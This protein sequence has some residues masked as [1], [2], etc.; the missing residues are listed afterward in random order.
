M[1]Y[2][3]YIYLD[4]RKPIS[5]TFQ[6]VTVAYQPFYVGKGQNERHMDHL[7]ETTENSGNKFKTRKIQKLHRLGLSPIIEQFH[8]TDDEEEA[9]QF[10]TKLICHWGR[11]GID[12]NGIL[13]NR[14]LENKPPNH[15]GRPKSEEQKQKMRESYWKR[16]SQPGYIHPCKGK[17]SKV[18]EEGRKKISA[19]HKGKPKSE[20]A[21]RKNSEAKKLLLKDPTKHPMFGKHQSEA[22]KQAISESKIG[23]K[24]SPQHIADLSD[25]WMIFPPSGASFK[26]DNLAQWCRD[27]DMHQGNMHRTSTTNHTC[28]GYKCKK[29]ES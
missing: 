13:T 10:E 11:E 23:S 27:N 1:K 21:K 20:E 14:E 4:P 29:L 28:K 12:S 19:T 26:I 22:A 8:F 5:Y 3:I 18:S 17:P 9:Y 7:N 15:K 16:V 2:Y 6:D 24:L 25:H